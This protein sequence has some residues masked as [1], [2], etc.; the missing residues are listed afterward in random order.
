[1]TAK[2]VATTANSVVTQIRWR[3]SSEG[4]WRSLFQVFRF[5]ADKIVDMEDRR[6]VQEARR[7]V[8]L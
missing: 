3:D 1:M 7:A 8:L 6:T 4:E 5:R 2:V